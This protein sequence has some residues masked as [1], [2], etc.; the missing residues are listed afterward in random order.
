MPRVEDKSNG[1]AGIKYAVQQRK[2][3]TFKYDDDT[4]IRTVEPFVHGKSEGGKLLLRGFQVK[5]ASDS[6]E[7]SG[8]K[9]FEIDK[10][11][12]VKIT[13]KG[14][15]PKRDKYNAKDEAMKEIFIAIKA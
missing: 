2:L 8:W 12:E 6:A 7:E 9:L 4:K 11:K 14:F 1:D 5:G 13:G 3:I 10:M 15:A